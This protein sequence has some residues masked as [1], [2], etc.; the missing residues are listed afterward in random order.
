MAYTI[1][2]G[3]DVKAIL[4][5]TGLTLSQLKQLNPEAFK[6]NKQ[7]INYAGTVLRT[8][9]KDKFYPAKSLTKAPVD[10]RQGIADSA[11]GNVVPTKPFSEVMPQE[12]WNQV[13]D[14]WTRNYVKTYMEPE[15]RTNVYEP[16]VKEYQKQLEDMNRQIGV[17]GRMS[18]AQDRA[19]TTGVDEAIKAEKDLRTQ[20]QSNVADVRNQIKQ[21]WAD[22]LYESQM[23]RYTDAPWRNQD[24]SKVSTDAGINVPNVISELNKQY[25]V[26][27]PQDVGSLVNSL[28]TWN[29]DLNNT[30]KTYDWTVPG[31]NTDIFSQ[32]KLN[33]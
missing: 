33:K 15:W 2:K 17:Q 26:T 27:G 21:S 32:Y 5:S 31:V 11:L 4:K 18:G 13:F 10:P 9:Y 23:K 20:Y 22:P 24:L 3:Q 12:Q 25:S 30:G 1:K 7:P 6:G 16:A 8:S 28:N 29:P 19:L 14:E